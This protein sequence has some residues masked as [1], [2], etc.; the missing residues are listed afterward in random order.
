MGASRWQKFVYITL[1]GLKRTLVF[2]GLSTTIMAFGLFTQVDVLTGGGPM[3][4]TSTLI[5][6][7]MRVGFREQDIAYGSAMTL[8][9]FLFVLMLSLGQKKLME[10]LGK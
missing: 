4:A 6:H 7:S 8:F 1:P 9:F 2:V 5:F 10:R 3:D